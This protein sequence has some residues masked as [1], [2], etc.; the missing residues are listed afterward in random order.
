M[1]VPHGRFSPVTSPV[2][3]PQDA[4]AVLSSA[5][6]AAVDSARAG[7]LARFTAD[8]A[9]L[10]ALDI[11]QVGILE[12]AVIRSLL[13]QAH[14]DGVDSADIRDLLTR[15]A[16]AASWFPDFTVDA[17]LLVLSGA[18]GMIDPEE[19]P[20]LERRLA[21]R[22]GALVIAELAGATP[23]VVRTHLGQAVG[24]IRRAETIELP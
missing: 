23:A 5:I 2:K 11:E 15:S 21:A 7:D 4:G 20:S 1:S 3:H 10:E 6:A 16:Q 12:A 14:P 8:C 22:H 24:E 18:L 9:R 19:Q 13:E 17:V